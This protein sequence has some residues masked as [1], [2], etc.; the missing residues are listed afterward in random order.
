MNAALCLTTLLA[1]V[2]LSWAASPEYSAKV[3]SA[4]TTCSKEYNAE[5]K[6]VLDIIKQNK[7][8]ET[9]DQ[10]CIV[11]CF[12]QKMDYLTDNKVDW[13]KVKALNPQ[14]YDTPDL[15]EKIN[16]VT[17]ACSKSVTQTSSDICEVG[18]PAIK[19]LKEEGDKVQLPKP[20]V[21]FE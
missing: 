17:D 12:F 4:L 19:C 1:V 8:P 2:C 21:K 5:L 18:V 13:S 10:K 7:L 14:K 9:K 16:Q 3:V 11:G 15:V 6:D 20:E